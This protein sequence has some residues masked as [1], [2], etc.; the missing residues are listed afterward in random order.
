MPDNANITPELLRQLL[1]YEPDTGMLFWLERPRSMFS[2]DNVFKMWNAKFSGAEA[3]S[4]K[5]PTGYRRGAV[6]NK[7]V[8]AHRVA[9]MILNG[10]IPTKIEIDHINGVRDDNRIVNLRMATN[11]DNKANCARR[12]DNTSGARGVH[13]CKQQQKWHAEIMFSV[14]KRRHIGFFDDISEAKNAYALASKMYHGEFS[15]HLRP[16]Q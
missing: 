3:L 12:S 1:R 15:I 13:W 14:G 8:K 6:F 16:V 10:E 5:D 11:A 4:Y 2:S 7:S 9:W